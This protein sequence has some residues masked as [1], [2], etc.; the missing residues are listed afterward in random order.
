MKNNFSRRHFIKT[1]GIAATGLTFVP[2]YLK[3]GNNNVA[4]Y[5]VRLGGPLPGNYTDP[6]EWVKAVKSLRYSAA[7]CPV[8]PGASGEQIKAFRAEA[9]RSNI[10]IAEV[11]AW[12]N[13][14]DP[15]ESVRTEAVKK[16]I[17]ALHL[18]DEIGAICC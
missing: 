6:T 18:A 7:Y 12:S 4:G 14:L 9:K 8:Q 15:N 10:M 5:H 2:T 3:A 13:M 17:A 11:G 1:G 16:N